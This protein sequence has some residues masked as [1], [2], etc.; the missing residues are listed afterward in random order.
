[1]NIADILVPM[2]FSPNAQCALEYSLSLIAPEGEIY[3]LHVIDTDF[4]ARLQEEGFSEPDVAIERMRQKAETRLQELINERQPSTVQFEAMVVIGKPFAE[5]L[6]VADD[7]DFSL[8]VLG[9]RGQRGGNIE[10]LLFGST[11]EKVLRAAP[12]PVVCVP[13]NWTS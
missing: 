6:R 9:T 12:V 10:E 11:A 2:D 13:P 1:M 7:L 5:I 4:I 8:I 3:L